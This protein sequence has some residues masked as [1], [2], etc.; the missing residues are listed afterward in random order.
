MIAIGGSIGTG[1][2]LASGNSLATAGP[3]GAVVAYLAIGIM[4]YFLMTSLGEIAS[5]L[6]ISGSFSTYSSRFI[7][8][9]LGFAM[10]WNFW[11][12]WSI[13]VAVE[14]SAGALIMKYWFPHSS[15]VL[16]SGLFL[17]LM[18]GLN[19]L[20]V[21]LYG[22]SEYWFA[23]IKVVTV[24]VFILVGLALIVGIL[25]D[26]PI[27]FK[28][29]TIGDAPFHGG[30]L[31]IL[32]VFMVA[33][34]SFQ[35]TEL[36]GISAGESENPREDVPRAIRQ[37]FWQILLFYILAI[38]IIGLI[39]PYTNPNLLKSDITNVA[40]SPF[41]LI[42]E[43]IG[44]AFAAS[45]MNAVILTAVLSAGNSSLYVSARMLYNLAKEGKAPNIFGRVNKNGVP[46]YALLLTAVIGALTFLSSLFGE[47]VIYLWLL[48]AASMSGFMAWV[49]I[50]ISHYRFRKA[51]VYQGRDLN[52]L[53][54]RAKWFP[55]GPIFAFVLCV[56]VMLGQ[57]YEIFLGKPVSWSDLLA[58]YIGIPFFLILW[59]GYKW[60]KKTK[61]IP[62]GECSFELKED[63]KPVK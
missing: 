19:L 52:E 53:P 13:T 9:A 28:N 7:D 54:Y 18:L 31:A 43:K 4:I 23:M 21:K 26:E 37:I 42:F 6:P 46:V 51:Y 50:A 12:S 36:V 24:I 2:F 25:G 33:G 57:R 48:N 59:L 20:T 29:F 10:G 44:L 39:I 32:G 8:P 5:F 38:L 17:A 40:V 15:S 41:T 62:L 49:G 1:L 61:V 60:T 55:F 35:G 30:F 34:F 47:G 63:Q 14:L 27:G 58:S 45:I 56:I 22:E 11:Y 16:W 3:G